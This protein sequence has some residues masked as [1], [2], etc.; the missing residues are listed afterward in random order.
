MYLKR[1][2]PGK[3]CRNSLFLIIKNN[4]VHQ[5]TMSLE[6]VFILIRWILIIPSDNTN[7]NVHLIED[8]IHLIRD[9]IN[10]SGNSN[11]TSGGIVVGRQVPII[12]PNCRK[13]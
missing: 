1:I 11:H 3:H 9:Y 8:F 2:D 6:T 7:N 12:I 10:L 5:S 4:S 13:K